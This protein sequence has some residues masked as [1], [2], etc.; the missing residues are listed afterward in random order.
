MKTPIDLGARITGLFVGLAALLVVSGRGE[1]APPDK[2][3][4][5]KS[6]AVQIDQLCAEWHQPASPGLSLAVARDGAVL[7][8]HTVGNANLELSVPLTAESVFQVASVSKQFTA[9]SILLLEQRGQL[10]L[11]DPV[12]KYLPEFTKHSRPPRKTVAHGTTFSCDGSLPNVVSISRRARIFNTVT[13][14]TF[15]SRRS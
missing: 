12:Q 5:A 15:C 9:M 6:L 2:R 4:S 1:D 8:E 7:Y 11:D 14:G 10:S 3:P 13:A